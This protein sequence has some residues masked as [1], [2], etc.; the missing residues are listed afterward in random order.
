MNVNE[1]KI[2]EIFDVLIHRHGYDVHNRDYLFQIETNWIDNNHGNYVL[3]FKNCIDLHCELNS[4]DFENLDWS[5][6]AV[7]A[8][9]G[10]KTVE[11]SKKESELTIKT[12]IDLKEVVLQTALYNLTLIAS[13]FD[14]KKLN[15]DSDLIDRFVYKI[16]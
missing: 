8:F 15:N 2:E 6:I 14:I 10:F 5:G 9:P 3:R 7:M 1:L 4:T 13:D 11:N 12:G 16:D